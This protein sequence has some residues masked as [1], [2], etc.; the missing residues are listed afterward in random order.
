MSMAGKLIAEKVLEVAF[1]KTDGQAIFNSDDVS[2]YK[3]SVTTEEK[4]KVDAH[5]NVVSKTYTG[6]KADITFD[7]T[8]YTPAIFAAIDGTEITEASA[9]NKIVSMFRDSVTVGSAED[10][11]VNTTI[12]LT[13]T[14]VGT[15]GSEVSRIYIEKSDKTLGE[16]FAVSQT[17]DATHFTVDASTKTIT[18]PIGANITADT[19]ITVYYEFESENGVTWSN[20]TEAEPISG[21][22]VVFVQYKDI[23]DKSK[24]F[25]GTEEFPSCVLSP[26]TERGVGADTT[27]SVALTATKDYCSKGG[28]LYTVTI[29]GE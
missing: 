25:I 3:C 4:E 18:L 22:F 29:P 24:K 7:T 8:F 13:H 19:V 23:C 15:T 26:N 20:E 6:K 9:T 27:Y 11:S 2:N 5:D 12:T 21:R 17:A 14:P 28:R 10:G 1:F 16:S